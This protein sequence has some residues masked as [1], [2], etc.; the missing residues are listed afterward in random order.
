MDFEIIARKLECQIAQE[1][2]TRGLIRPKVTIDKNDPRQ[3]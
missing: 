3:S 1:S 2:A